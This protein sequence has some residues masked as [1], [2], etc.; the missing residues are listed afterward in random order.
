M[1]KICIKALVQAEARV[2]HGRSDKRGGSVCV[3][4]QHPRKGHSVRAKFV[5]A[6]IVHPCR[7]G[8]L[9]R[10]ERR[11]RWQRYGHGRIGLG[12]PDA[13]ARKLVDTGSPDRSVPVACKMVS[14]KSIDG[15]EDH[16]G[17]ARRWPFR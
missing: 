3:V 13:L 6:E 11:M 2:E 15:D 16:T 5:A 12:E 17:A 14:T 10:H 8:K 7:H 9:P 1:V 4:S